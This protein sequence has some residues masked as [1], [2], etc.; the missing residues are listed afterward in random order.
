M[1]V[2]GKV[3]CVWMACCIVKKLWHWGEG[4]REYYIDMDSDGSKE[5]KLTAMFWRGGV[6]CTHTYIYIHTYIYRPVNL[7]YIYTYIHIYIYTYIHIYIYTYI[8]I[9]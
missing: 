6:A 2:F 8:Y 4:S 3:L 1:F 9:Y 7:V 5:Q